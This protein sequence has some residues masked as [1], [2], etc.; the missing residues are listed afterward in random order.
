MKQGLQP[1][2]GPASAP[3]GGHPTPS[4]QG[5]ACSKSPYFLT[6]RPARGQVLLAD[7][8]WVEES[9]ALTRVG[10]GLMR[11]KCVLGW[12]RL[13]SGLQVPRTRP[14]A[15]RDQASESLGEGP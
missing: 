11:D 13:P 12:G 6:L 1:P 9:Y 14:A 15:G 5:N 4:P 8:P 3:R 2:P 7:A 10:A